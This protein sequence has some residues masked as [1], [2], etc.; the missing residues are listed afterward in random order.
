MTERGKRRYGVCLSVPTAAAAVMPKLAANVSFG[1]WR[2][3]NFWPPRQ[4]FTTGDGVNDDV[5]VMYDQN[6][7]I[8]KRYKFR[9]NK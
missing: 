1:Q 8:R 2:N 7:R 3:Y 5:T 4:T 9:N 6:H